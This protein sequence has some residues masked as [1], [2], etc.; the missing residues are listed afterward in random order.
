M[1]APIFRRFYILAFAVERWPRFKVYARLLPIVALRV[2]E[3]LA[4]LFVRLQIGEEQKRHEE[5]IAFIVWMPVVAV[6]LLFFRQ[7]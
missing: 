3:R 4:P 5:F 1:A 2:L 7:I 6:L